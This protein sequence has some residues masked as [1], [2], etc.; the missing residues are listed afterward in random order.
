[1]LRC[2]GSGPLT[3]LPFKAQ[4]DSVDHKQSKLSGTARENHQD[5][6]SSLALPHKVWEEHSS[7]RSVGYQGWG[8]SSW[9]GLLHI[10]GMMKAVVGRW[11]FCTVLSVLTTWT[12]TSRA[13]LPLVL[14]TTSVSPLLSITLPGHTARPCRQQA[15]NQVGYQYKHNKGMRK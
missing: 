6:N 13:A 12:L 9:R 8:S 3:G 15:R 4:E 2:P 10:P 5:G 1:M 11:V 7:T 14:L